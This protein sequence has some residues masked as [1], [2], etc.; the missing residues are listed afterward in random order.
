LT[1]QVKCTSNIFHNAG[2][3]LLIQV[4]KNIIIRFLSSV[5]T[6]G[7]QAI[8]NHYWLISFHLFIITL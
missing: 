2:Y 4:I 6:T 1:L 3:K 8:H 5:S 7:L